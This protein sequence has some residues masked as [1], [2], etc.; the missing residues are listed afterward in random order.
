MSSASGPVL[1]ESTPGRSHIALAGEFDIDS[2]PCLDDVWETAGDGVRVVDV[3]G[4][5]FA[6]ASFLNF[7]LTVRGRLV[8]AG[9]LPEQLA[10]LFHL[11]GTTTLFTYTADTTVPAG[12]GA[13]AGRVRSGTAAEADPGVPATTTAGL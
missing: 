5:A 1:P 8:L 3:S 10:R 4:V 6:D 12:P 7:L 2:A 13:A 11:T 9:P